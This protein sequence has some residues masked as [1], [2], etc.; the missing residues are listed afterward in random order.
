MVDCFIY[1]FLKKK[2]LLFSNKITNSLHFLKPDFVTDFQ[3]AYLEGVDK[4]S[5]ISSLPLNHS[6][7]CGGVGRVL[8][9]VLFGGIK[10]SL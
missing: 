2:S 8:L 3:E 9:K 1:I 10:Y 5:I 6:V 7:I 4:V